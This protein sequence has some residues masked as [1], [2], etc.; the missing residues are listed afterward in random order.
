MPG[1]SFSKDGGPQPEGRRTESMGE[2]SW[3]GDSKPPPHQPGG[4]GSAV[5]STSGSGAQ[6]FSYILSALGRF[7]FSTFTGCFING[8]EGFKAQFR[9]ASSYSTAVQTAGV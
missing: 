7:S 8:L 2:G 1:H 3:R 6:R 4:L 9:G 5:R